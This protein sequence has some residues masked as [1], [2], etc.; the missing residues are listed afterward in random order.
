[1]SGQGNCFW[2]HGFPVNHRNIII[3]GQAVDYII[4]LVAKDILQGRRMGCKKR[5]SSFADSPT[6]PGRRARLKENSGP[7]KT[8]SKVPD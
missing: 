3:T 4:A 2:G 8:I 7:I 6:I 5:A 1:M